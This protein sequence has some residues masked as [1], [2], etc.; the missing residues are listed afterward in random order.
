M[1]FIYLVFLDFSFQL[2]IEREKFIERK[3]YVHMLH[4]AKCEFSAWLFIGN[5]QFLVRSELDFF[6]LVYFVKITW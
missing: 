3:R 4:T 2:M 1:I 5:R 6:F